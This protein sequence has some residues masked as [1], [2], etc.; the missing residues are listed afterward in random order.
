MTWHSLLLFASVHSRPEWLYAPLHPATARPSLPV[1]PPNPS[2][3]SGTRLASPLSGTLASASPLTACAPIPPA[4]A[5]LD[6]QQVVLVQRGDCNFD[7]KVLH[8]QAAGYAA[9]VVF[10]N[11]ATEALFTSE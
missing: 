7:V 6:V 5:G 11:E 4:R 3:P 2:S 9:A 8:A 10:N 1:S